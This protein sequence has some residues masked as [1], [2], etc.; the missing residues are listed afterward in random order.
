MTP[1]NYDGLFAANAPVTTRAVNRHAQYD[2]AVAY[3]DPDTL[4]LYGLCTT[5]PP[6]ML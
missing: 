1:F 4:P 5:P 3:H 6:A 2:F